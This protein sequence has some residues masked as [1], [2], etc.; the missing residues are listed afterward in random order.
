MRD[1]KWIEEEVTRRREAGEPPL[2]LTEEERA[3][4]HGDPD[5]HTDGGLNYAISLAKRWNEGLY[6]SK[7]DKYRCK[8]FAK[9]FGLKLNK[10]A[11]AE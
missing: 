1:P 9:E 3:Y 2:L 10:R 11:K 8:L 4:F 6:L 7:Y 5:W